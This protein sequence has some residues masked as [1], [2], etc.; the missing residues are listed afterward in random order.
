MLLLSNEIPIKKISGGYEHSLLLSHDAEVYWFGNNGCE[1]QNTPKKITINENKFID[2]ASHYWHKIS[3]ALSMKGIYYVW[4]NCGENEMIKEPKETEFKSF[5]DIFNHYFGITYETTEDERFI[6]F[7]IELIKN[8]KYLRECK[9]IGKLGEGYYGQVFR[10]KN[11]QNEEYA[12]KKMRFTIDEEK[13]L[14]KELENFFI[15]NNLD[16]S[17]RNILKLNELWLENN[18][19]L[20]NKSEKS[21]TLYMQMELCDKTLE[22]FII[23]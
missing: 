1:E 13:N 16:Y 3:I 6:D 17:I 18:Q 15:S 8:G 5:N 22:E 11:D 10:V 4:G 7:K 2:I 21:L 23:Y 19:T 12:I 14:L 9:E 20:E